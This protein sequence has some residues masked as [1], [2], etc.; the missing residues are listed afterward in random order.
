MLQLDK[1]SLAFAGHPLFEEASFTLQ[2]GERCGLVGRNGSGKSTLLKL[3]NHELEPDSGNIIIPKYYKIG[4]LKQHIHF[5]EITLLDEA[6]LGLPIDQR[7]DLYKAEAILFGLGFT[8]ADL[9]RSPSDFSGGYQLRLNLVKVLLSEPDCLLLDEPTNYLDIVSIRWLT[10]FLSKWP[11]EM[12]LI[13]HDRDF[14]DKVTTHIM[15]VHREKLRKLKGS[16]IDFF[17]HVY[18]EEELHEKNRQKTDKKRQHLQ[19]FVDRFGA[20]ASKATQAQSKQKMLDRVPVLEKLNAL[21]ELSFA[22][23]EAPFPGKKM[24]DVKN[25]C[26]AYTDKLLIDDFSMEIEKQE[27][28]AI[29]GKNGRGKSTLLKLIGGELKPISGSRDTSDNLRIGYFGQTHVDRLKPSHT[30]E[31][32]I[33]LANHALN[34]TEIKAIAGNMMF[35]GDLSSKKISILSGGE[36]SRVLLGKIIAKPCNMLL[37]DEPTHHLDIESIEALIDALETFQG[38][39]VIVTH[40]ELILRRLKLDKIVICE[41][42]K[43]TL[44]LGDYDT[45]LEKLGWQE[46]KK[47][48]DSSK[49][50]Q[51]LIKNKENTFQKKAT[52]L[53]PIE[54]K[55]EALEKKLHAL[56]EKQ[57]NNTSLLENGDTSSELLKHLNQ[58]QK[59]LDLVEAE[60]Y[61]LYEELEKKR[62]EIDS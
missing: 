32:E 29:I 38:T 43:Q 56:E 1:V 13:S 34:F 9:D 6:A 36:K 18:L 33:A 24:L 62:L 41:D 50:T 52:L 12:I 19:S 28:I 10:N 51:N 17:E 35:S 46:E 37:L 48:S 53:R 58:T 61:K 7:D 60:L 3:I 21:S 25:I 30:I 8:K 5:T 4:Y 22:F 26:F 49:N 23:Q 47:E 11:G 59:E 57:K 16:T 44:F 45:F 27:R 14:M 20:K 39:V 55:I 54:R 15:G 2:K 40:S 42:G 31:E